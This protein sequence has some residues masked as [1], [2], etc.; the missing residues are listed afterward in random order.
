MFIFPLKNYFVACC[1][2]IAEPDPSQTNVLG[3]KSLTITMVSK[4]GG[5]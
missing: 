5:D 2:N 1:L 3:F 4:N